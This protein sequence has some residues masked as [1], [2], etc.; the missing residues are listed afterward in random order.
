MHRQAQ[1]FSGKKTHSGPPI[2]FI[3]RFT[4]RITNALS[5]NQK[6]NLKSCIQELKENNDMYQQKQDLISTS[7][8]ALKELGI[9]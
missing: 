3:S 7:N 5:E 1:I 8:I 9:V 4:I 6:N 2:F